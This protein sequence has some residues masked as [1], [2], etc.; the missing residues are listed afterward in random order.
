MKVL[1]VDDNEVNRRIVRE[2]LTA[3]GVEVCEAEDGPRGLVMIDRD[4]FDLVLM[5]LRM[6]GMDGLTAIDHIRARSDPKAKIPVIVVTADDSADLRERCV[7]HGADG[8]VRKPVDMN[9][10]FTAIG[11]SALKCGR[12]ML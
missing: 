1:F 4:D 5:D 9:E 2:M 12:V 7:G 6:P 10:L 8:L 3:A 11:D